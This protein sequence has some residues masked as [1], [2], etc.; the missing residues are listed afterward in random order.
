MFIIRGIRCFVYRAADAKTIYGDINAMISLKLIA[1]RTRD[2]P[3]SGDN[4]DIRAI[5][6]RTTIDGPQAHHEEVALSKVML[7]MTRLTFRTID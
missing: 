1:G 4:P 6:A 3:I 5:I 7:P 2:K